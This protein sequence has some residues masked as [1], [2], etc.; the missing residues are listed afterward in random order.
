MI[1]YYLKDAIFDLWDKFQLGRAQKR[2]ESYKCQ[3]D[4]AETDFEKSQLQVWIN[5]K[6]EEKMHIH[7][8]MTARDIRSSKALHQ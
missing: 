3:L 5:F 8:R 7:N 6:I 2:I 1:L 4:S